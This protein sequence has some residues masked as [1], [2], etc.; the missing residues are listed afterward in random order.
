[1]ASGCAE[2]W[3][4]TSC[5]RHEPGSRVQTTGPWHAQSPARVL[6][7]RRS[8]FCALTLVSPRGRCGAPFAASHTSVV[9]VGQYTHPA[10]AAKHDGTERPKLGRRM[11]SAPQTETSHTRCGDL[12]MKGSAVRIRSSAL[13]PSPAGKV[14]DRP[15]RPSNPGSVAAMPTPDGRPRDVRSPLA[16]RSVEF[17][18]CRH[19]CSW[20]RT[21]KCVPDAHWRSSSQRSASRRPLKRPRG[22][23]SSNR[24]A[25]T[26]E[27][28]RAASVNLAPRKTAATPRVGS[29]QTHAVLVHGEFG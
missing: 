19:R 27:G 24:V 25:L 28:P 20:R 7:V 17:R 22:A 8:I 4:A 29:S 12:V 6:P 1:M 23:D 16:W 14:T 26:S 9:T 21:H 2:A 5:S 15:F 10:T 11:E 3:R 13:P 18:A